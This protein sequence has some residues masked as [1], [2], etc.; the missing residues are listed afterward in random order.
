VAIECDDIQIADLMNGV[1][2][3]KQINYGVSVIKCYLIY[4]LYFVFLIMSPK[5]Y[6]CRAIHSCN[7]DRKLTVTLQQTFIS[8]SNFDPVVPFRP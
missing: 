6:S 3:N 2:C 8:G 4:A 7:C 5:W 1:Q